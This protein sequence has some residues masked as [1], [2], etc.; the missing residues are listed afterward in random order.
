MSED[1]DD[2]HYLSAA[3][4]LIGRSLTTLP[5]P[6][7]EDVPIG[8][9]DLYESLQQSFSKLWLH[10]SKDYLMSLQRLSK[11][12][13]SSP[14]L[15]ID[16]PALII[17]KFPLTNVC[18]LGVIIELHSGADDHVRVVTIRTRH[19]LFKRAITKFGPLP[20]TED[21]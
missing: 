10:W 14:K 9:L 1:I 6:D 21:A 15:K 4:F 3:H 8:S 20:I 13:T 5:L 19:G 18:S 7:L 11:W 17:E 12:K 16:Q 2:F